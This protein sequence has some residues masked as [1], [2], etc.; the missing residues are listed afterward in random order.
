MKNKLKYSRPNN[1]PN[2][3]AN[4][5]QKGLVVSRFGGRMEFGPRALGNR[6]ILYRPDKPV[7][8]WLNKALKRNEFMPFAPVTMY[9]Y[10]HDCYLK[11]KGAE[12]S[13]E[14]MTITFECTE[15]MKRT[16]PAVVHVDGTARP[17]L[18]K[19]DQN[20]FYY[21]IVKYFYEK[22]GIPSIVNT[23]FNI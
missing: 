8:D 13:A 1:P 11:L 23:S 19:H 12:R 18:I 5:L 6:S 21:D 4:C 17:Q 14:Y 10:A 22:T 2:E 7:N 9:E 16:S 15:K 20:P 3:V